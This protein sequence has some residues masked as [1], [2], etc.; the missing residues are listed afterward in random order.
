M[1]RLLRL[2]SLATII[3]TATMSVSAVSASIMEGIDIETSVYSIQDNDTLRL[4][5]LTPATDTTG[6]KK[7]VV[8]FLSGGGWEGQARR[9]AITD[10]YPLLPY[11]VKHGYIGV[12]ADYRCDFGRSRKSGIIPDHNIGEFVESGTLAT[13]GVTEAIDRAVKMAVNDLFNATRYVIDNADHYN[14]DPSRIVVIGSS[15]G[16]ITAL[17]AEHDICIN[18][19]KA[20]KI[21]P[22]G[23]N[24]AAIIPMAGGVWCADSKSDTLQWNRKPCPVLMFH[25]DKDPIV[26]YTTL[27]VP[28]HHWSMNGVHDIA[29]QLSRMGVP[30]TLY[31]YA[32]MDHDAAVVP[33]NTKL[34]LIADFLNSTATHPVAHTHISPRVTQWP[35]GN[36]SEF[37][38]KTP[39]DSVSRIS[40]LYK[41][42]GTDSIYLD[43]FSPAIRGDKKTPILFYCH[44]GGWQAGDR[45]DMTNDWLDMSAYFARRG[46]TVVTVDYRLKFLEDRNS[47]RIP[48]KDIV[49]YI[50]S[51]ELDNPQ[52]WSSVSDAIDIAIDDTADALAYT[53]ANADRWN[54]DTTRVVG[55]GGSAGAITLLTM[56]HRL[57][58][59]TD[60]TLTSR[61]PD[62]FNFSALIPMAGG[63]WETSGN[64]T[65]RWDNP[66]CPLLMFHGDND[67]IVTYN[68]LHFDRSHASLWGSRYI[69]DQLRQMNLPYML[70]TVTGG[71]HAWSANP[72]V[73]NREDIERTLTRMLDDGEN[74]QL[75]IRL[76]TPGYNRNGG[77]FARYVAERQSAQ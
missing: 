16:A 25:G 36:V 39:A 1:T 56:E 72:I 69:A 34:D 43:V 15:A 42:V 38:K 68:T 52:I 75:D 32:G 3:L 40:H 65:L 19:K 44:G 60:S 26:S 27:K 66:P 37:Y 28:E 71:D 21:L 13:P 53:L 73:F 5:V 45:F 62:G 18:D 10:T 61:L 23:F 63:V 8:I 22:R 29:A 2:I 7:P 9:T 35:E 57:C 41:T 51:G 12:A 50:V 11:F 14:A 54:A 24:Y 76:S 30:H 4:D 70:Y 77:W 55:I 47:G 59:N 31:T 46:W 6:T 67:P 20:R 48:D 33:M 49:H 74:I 64:D 58:N 17:T